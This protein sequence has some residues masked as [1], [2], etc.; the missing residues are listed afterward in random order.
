MT[1]AMSTACLAAL[2]VAI[3]GGCG[4]ERETGLV[5]AEPT[6]R[7][8]AALSEPIT[9]RMGTRAVPVRCA[10]GCDAARAQL[11]GLR[12]GCLADPTSTPHHL[13]PAPALIALGCCTEAASA[14]RRACEDATTGP[15]VSR[16]SAECDSGRI[17][18]P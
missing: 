8:Q 15:C 10:L 2:A 16:W 3:L 13:D 11:T 12:D 5:P 1:G 17:P 4:D 14:Y 6:P 18:S 9:V 7:E